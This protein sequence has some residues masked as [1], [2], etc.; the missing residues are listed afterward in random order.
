MDGG[1]QASIKTGAA[2]CGPRRLNTSTD[3]CPAAAARHS[4]RKGAG[5]DSWRATAGRNAKLKPSPLPAANCRRR[6]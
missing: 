2:A 5:D 1:S 3:N 4:K 6:K